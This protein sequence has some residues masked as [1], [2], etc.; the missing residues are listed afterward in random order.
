M[1]VTQ[2][3]EE[4]IIMKKGLQIYLLMAMAALPLVAQGA[5]GLAS[6]VFAQRHQQETLS[7]LLDRQDNVQGIRNLADGLTE[8]VTAA[9]DMQGIRN[10]ARNLI[11]AVKVS[12]DARQ[13]MYNLI[14]GLS[15]A[16][17]TAQDV[18][19]IGNLFDALAEA[20]KM[21]HLENLWN[22][23][24]QGLG[25]TTV[26]ELADKL[27]HAT[28]DSIRSLPETVVSDVVKT[29]QMAPITLP[30]PTAENLVV[31]ASEFAPMMEREA[32]RNF[33]DMVE[34]AGKIST[35]TKLRYQPVNTIV[36]GA[37]R[38]YDGAKAG[39]SQAA[40]WVKTKCPV[41]SEQEVTREF[42]FP[43][44]PTTGPVCESGQGVVAQ[45]KSFVSGLAAKGVGLLNSAREK[46]APY[47]TSGLTK[48]ASLV[49]Q[50]GQENQNAWGKLY[51][52]S[53]NSNRHPMVQKVLEQ[54]YHNPKLATTI[55][56]TAATATTGYVAYKL[57]QSRNF[58]KK[59][60][61][62]KSLIQP[63]I[64]SC[65]QLFN[66]KPNSFEYEIKYNGA[67]GQL[68]SIHKKDPNVIAWILKNINADKSFR[69]FAGYF[70]RV[71]PA[72]DDND[73]IAKV[74]K[75][76][77]LVELRTI[78]SLING[79]YFLASSNGNQKNPTIELINQYQQKPQLVE[80]IL[81][82]KWNSDNK[83]HKAFIQFCDNAARLMGI[84]N[85][86]DVSSVDEPH[87]FKGEMILDELKKAAKV[88]VV[89]KLPQ[90]KAQ[91]KQQPQP[92]QQKKSGWLSSRVSSWASSWMPDVSGAG[93]GF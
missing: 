72:K 42:G 6:E 27:N 89:K 7:L 78:A 82:T 85:W 67:Y 51:V 91:V 8:A 57:V 41:V 75:D 30:L 73:R 83:E 61:E 44:V 60:A 21:Q 56:A 81:L 12:E 20:A 69:D 10:L 74:A 31:S 13:A 40:S 76:A 15:E 32:L 11:E 93:I 14:S 49:Q 88:F 50:V 77:D 59:V 1:M 5:Q 25:E 47:V 22:D 3:H 28:M 70:R 92:A 9:Q 64:S 16:A 54:A 84:K 87:K 63:F 35:F 62:C 45:G 66:I 18:Q 86:I 39:L 79:L 37:S 17:R 23:F 34:G 36:D 58:T 46:A 71:K 90:P 80:R 38:M 65:E 4:L 48:A 2:K 68:V 19:R 55:T 24:V 52:T 26:R 43:Q 33:G 29:V 53:M